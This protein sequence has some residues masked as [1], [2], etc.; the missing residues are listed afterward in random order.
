MPL[1]F[2]WTPGEKKALRLFVSAEDTEF[3]PA[4][5]QHWKDEGF[6]VAFL[7]YNGDPAEYR[8][9]LAKMGDKLDLG[10]KWAL[11]GQLPFLMVLTRLTN[12]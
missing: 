7:S 8:T 2:S 1:N 6:H 5:L 4:T 12:E 10:E 11:I 3:D 9:T